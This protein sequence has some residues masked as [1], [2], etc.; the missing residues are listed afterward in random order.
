MIDVD[1]R[2]GGDGSLEGLEREHSRVPMTVEC[3][4]GGGG[5]HLYFAHPDVLNGDLRLEFAAAAVP[6]EWQLL[7]APKGRVSPSGASETES[8]K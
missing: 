7:A 6:G 1:V 2:H 3:R 5:R 8:S 4:T